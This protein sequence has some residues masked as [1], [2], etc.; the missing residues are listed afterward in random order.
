MRTEH[1]VHPPSKQSETL[2]RLFISQMAERKNYMNMLEAQA[3]ANIKSIRRQTD[4]LAK[5]RGW[6]GK[7]TDFKRSQKWHQK[8]I[9]EFRANAVEFNQQLKRHE[10]E[11]KAIV[12][13][14]EEITMAI[15]HVNNGAHT[16]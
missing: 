4:L 13:R 6:L 9:E 5:L 10:L 16:S 14:L 3:I 1:H 11:S 15:A 2:N 12:R 8:C 7:N